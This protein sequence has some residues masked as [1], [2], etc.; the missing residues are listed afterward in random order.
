[1]IDWTKPVCTS[2]ETPHIGDILP[3]CA[4]HGLKRVAIFSPSQVKDLPHSIGPN[5]T[6]VFR[7]AD[8][9]STRGDGEPSLN[10]LVNYDPDDGATRIGLDGRKVGH[11]VA[12]AA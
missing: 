12:Q 8:D 10:D 4:I 2:H 9:G 1:M 11:R 6:T 5:R 3:D 7:Y